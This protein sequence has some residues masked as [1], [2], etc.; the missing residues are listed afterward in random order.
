SFQLNSGNGGVSLTGQPSA[1]VPGQTYLLTV[2]VMPAAGSRVYG[3]QLSAVIDGANPPQ[4]AGILASVNNAVQVICGP[5]PG[6]VSRPGIS[7]SAP[8]AI[9]FAEHTNADSTQ[10]FT[11]NWTAPSSASAGTV[12]FNVAGNSA[13]GDHSP[14][15]DHIYTQ[16]Y[17]V[18]PA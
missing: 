4:Q 15:G 16:V 6:S 2:T 12:R 5:S 13:N 10:T 3:F 1:W 17:R 11:V 18:D 9:Q 8:S 7:C 14:T